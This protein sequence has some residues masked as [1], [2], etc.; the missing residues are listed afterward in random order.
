MK[1]RSC[2]KDS[3]IEVLDLGMAPPSNRLF[4]RDF[5]GST[6]YLPLRVCVCTN[7][8]LL[9]TS[10]FVVREDVF[11]E[12]YVYL[13]STS[14]S[15]L[16]HCSDYVSMIKEKLKLSNRSLVIEIASNDGYLLQ[17]FKDLGIPSLGIEPT[18]LP[19]RLAIDKGIETLIEFFGQETAKKVSTKYGNADLI[20]GNNVLAHVPDIKDF[21]TG[22]KTLLTEQ[23]TATFEFPYAVN[24]FDYNQYDTV[25]HEHF[26]YL[27]LSSVSY[28]FEQAGMRIFD[29]EELDT[30]GGSLR[31]YV[32]HAETCLI[33][34]TV[35]RILANE[36]SIGITNLEYYQEWSAKVLS[37]K[38]AV[39][40]KFVEW[41]K[42]GKKIV[43]YGAAAKGNTLLNYCGIDVD[44][45]DA[46]FD[47]A[48]SKQNKI[49]PGSRI[50]IFA[51]NAENI[52]GAD[53]IV[54]FPWNLKE[55]I[56]TEIRTK[57]PQCEADLYTLVPDIQKLP[58][59]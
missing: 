38:L 9:Q 46:I 49:C 47:N 12:D 55:E 45:I 39:L 16:R 53:I 11:E 59:A 6:E 7:C 43:G 57:Y 41:K 23:G 27:T 18:I 35:A 50:P 22:V 33:A 2:S 10:D 48:S 4:E 42:Q 31:I 28:V 56:Q 37:H 15:W 29:V 20:V 40:Q 5:V 58:D 34:P 19:A 25:Y 24:L 14:T 44:F 3:L 52:A 17:F 13:S 26:S 32:G 21:A 36:N 8:W 51:P 54:I 1:C 30:H